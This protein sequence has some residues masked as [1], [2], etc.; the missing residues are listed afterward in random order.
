[1]ADTRHI[2]T[3]SPIASEDSQATLVRTATGH[4]LTI[5]CW[6][7]TTTDLRTMTTGDDWPSARTEAIRA[8]HRP[9]LSALADLC[10][11]RIATWA[12]EDAHTQN[13]DDQ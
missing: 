5:G 11:A 1:M 7:G 4:Q 10:D 2:L 8:T 13:G 3:V 9:E 6:T 12:T